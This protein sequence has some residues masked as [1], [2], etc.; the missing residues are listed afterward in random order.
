MEGIVTLWINTQNFDGT[1]TSKFTCPLTKTPASL[2]V[3]QGALFFALPIHTATMTTYFLSH[4]GVSNFIHQIGSNIGLS[5]TPPFQFRHSR[6]NV[7]D[8][9]S[10]ADIHEWVSYSVNDQLSMLAKLV[11]SFQHREAEPS[12]SI[13][14]KDNHFVTVTCSRGVNAAYRFN[15]HLHTTATYGHARAHTLYALQFVIAQDTQ[16]PFPHCEFVWAAPTVA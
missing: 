12:F 16:N 6:F 14:V 15:L 9:M 13:M 3:D 11:F 4:A 7:D 8:E 2:L 5:A 10:E 1:V